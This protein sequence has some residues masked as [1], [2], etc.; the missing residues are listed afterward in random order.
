MVFF[1]QNYSLPFKKVSP[2]QWALSFLFARWTFVRGEKISD[3]L[4]Q[5]KKFGQNKRQTIILLGCKHLQ[6][7]RNIRHP[8]MKNVSLHSLTLLHGDMCLLQ[9]NH[10][11]HPTMIETCIVVQYPESLWLHIW[12]HYECDKGS[13]WIR[14]VFAHPFPFNSGAPIASA[15]FAISTHP[16]PANIKWTFPYRTCPTN[17]GSVIQDQRVG[18]IQLLF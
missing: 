16:P 14:L 8:Y 1:L 2:V 10:H 6:S 9:P 15:N 11:V 5:I 13:D 3:H 12:E 4:T 7:L 17:G 18:T